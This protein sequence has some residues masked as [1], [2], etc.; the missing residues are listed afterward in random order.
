MTNHNQSFFRP[1]LRS[2][3]AKFWLLAFLF[4]FIAFRL[5]SY[6]SLLATYLYLFNLITFPFA[7]LFLGVW[8]KKRL[9]RK[10]RSLFFP[11]YQNILHLGSWQVIVWYLLKILLFYIIW[12][13]SWILG[14]LGLLFFYH[15]PAK[16]K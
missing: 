9:P 10:I 14:P 12:K 7:A 8:A 13:F 16:H 1:L 2:Q 11:S 15:L 5:Q 6:T 4:S 3:P